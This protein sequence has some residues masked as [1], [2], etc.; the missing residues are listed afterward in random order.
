MFQIANSSFI[1]AILTA[2]L[3]PEMGVPSA[4]V[5]D[6]GLFIGWV[7]TK[8]PLFREDPPFIVRR[9]NDTDA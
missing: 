2:K 4:V 3:F 9:G 5:K 1:L 6:V 7:A 8:R